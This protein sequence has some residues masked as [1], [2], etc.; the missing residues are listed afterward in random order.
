M[1]DHI[2]IEFDK[3]SAEWICVAYLSN[4]ARMLDVVKQGKDPHLITG[5]LLSGAPE[6]LV[7]KEDRLVR[8]ATDPIEIEHLR[9][10]LPELND[11][12]L[13]RVYSIRQM[14]KRCNHALNYGMGYRRFALETEVDETE[15]KRIV[16]TY[17]NQAYPGIKIWWGA[18]EEQL[19]RN[20]RTL[21]NC[22][23]RKCRLLDAWGVELFEKARS[24]LPQS[25]VTDMVHEGM[26][27]CFDDQSRPFRPL[28][29]L[30]DGHDSLLYQYPVGRWRSMAFAVAKMA[31]DYM[32]PVAIYSIKEFKIDT[33]VTIGLDWGHMEKVKISP[34]YKDINKNAE[35]IRKTWERLRGEAKAA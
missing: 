22:F 24:F 2:L 8:K 21:V 31:F 18:I 14:A 35:N 34:R 30:E 1:T 9:S 25:T 5:S 17:F 19:R 23:G 13:P 26:I 11:Y 15:A 6:E 3:V 20:D 10:R 32:S 29:L 16:N 12:F 33:E 7:A 4:D 28:E 27:K